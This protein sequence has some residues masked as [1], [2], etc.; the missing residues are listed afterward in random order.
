MIS[1][2]GFCSSYSETYHYIKSAAATQGVDVVNEIAGTFY[3]Y[4]ADIIDHDS[5]TIDG[6]GTIHI[7]GQMATLTV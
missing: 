3:Q 2:L 4:Q 7:M 6:T 5:R 1:K